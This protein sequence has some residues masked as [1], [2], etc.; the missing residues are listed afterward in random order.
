MQEAQVTVDGSTY[1]LPRPFLVVATQNPVEMEGTY[2]LP[3][4][5]R[6]RFMARLTVGYPEVDAELAMLDLQETADPLD[7]LHPVTDAAQVR[8]LIETTRHLYAAPAVKQYVVDLV[9]ATRDDAGLRLG[10]SPRASI[11]LLRAAKGLAAVSGRDHVL[12]DD[13][14]T[15]AEPVLAHR[16]IPSAESRLSGR[17]TRDVVADIVAR[18]PVAS[19]TRTSVRDR[20]VAG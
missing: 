2:P 20:S 17:S 10:A 13:V 19:P 4:A 18:V 11:Q 7:H 16:L 6:D 3:E 9:A 14:Q 5:Q 12:P 15:L 8:R 1:P